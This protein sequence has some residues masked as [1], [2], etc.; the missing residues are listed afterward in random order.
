VGR[1]SIALFR[2]GPIAIAALVLCAPVPAEEKPELKNWFGD[3]YFQLTRE[4]A[5]CPEPL[6]PYMSEA[7]ALRYSHHRAER[8]TRCYQ[9]KRCR[10]PSSYDYDREIAASIQRDFAGK[11]L[12]LPRSTLWVLV[13]GRRVWI[14]GCVAPGYRSGS[15]SAMLKRIPD[16]ELAME[17]VRVGV[18]GAIPYRKR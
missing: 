10:L 12:A 11:R 18:A 15:L 1:P 2:R 16:V 3:P 5:S 7:E 4:I 8:G 6:G 17:E 13:Q 14:Q 9:E